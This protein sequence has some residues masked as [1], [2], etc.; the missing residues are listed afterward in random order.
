M[1]LYLSYSGFDT[2]RNCPKH[3]HLK[4]V[5]K[6]EPPVKESKHNAIVGTVVQQVFADFLNKE[7]WR[8][9]SE[10]TKELLRLTDLYFWEYLDNNHVDF[11]DIT[12]RFKH[13]T[14]PLNECL[15]MVPKILQLW[16]RER[17]LGPYAK[18]EVDVRVRYRG[19]ETLAGYLD[20]VIRKD[21]GTIMI[22]DGKASRH[23]D[24][25]VN[26]DQLYFYAL[27]FYLKYQKLPDKLGFIFYA[28]ADDEDKG[29][30]WI[31]VDKAKIKNLREQ[32]E[33]A[34][35]SIY[36]GK[37]K[38]TPKPSNCR[39]CPFES[40]CSERLSQKAANSFKRRVNSTKP[41]EDVPEGEFIG[42]GNK[43]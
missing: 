5:K 10:T 13:P 31:E 32:V 41:E 19:S 11:N 40:V 9:G 28:F 26:E 17:F 12:C 15:E 33:D 29:V 6:E 39:F 2:Y 42:F 21:D 22:L 20:F 43:T 3:Y 24:K 18:S 38:A 30:K 7:L 14:E 25:Y 1:S 16:K 27:L 35:D 34:F 4:Y 37:W 23:H 8:K 36:Q